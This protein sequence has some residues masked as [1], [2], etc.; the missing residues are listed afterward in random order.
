[1]TDTQTVPKKASALDFFRTTVLELKKVDW[2][3]RE[4]TIRLTLIV[5][6]VSLIIGMFIGGL[7]I[8]LTQAVQELLEF[9]T[10]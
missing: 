8:L 10:K 4:K 6:G 7:D 2:P 9:K 5:I 1:M 3:T